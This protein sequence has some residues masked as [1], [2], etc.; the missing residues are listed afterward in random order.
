M[1]TIDVSLMTLFTIDLMMLHCEIFFNCYHDKIVTIFFINAIITVNLGF[2]FLFSDSCNVCN[3][4]SL[5]L[6]E[7]LY[8]PMTCEAG[9]QFCMN[10]L[11]NNKDGSR[12]LD[13]K[14]VF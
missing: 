4:M 14:Y 5:S 9:K 6:C 11:V 8:T 13:R 12:T 7:I 1:K 10:V 2:F 3:G